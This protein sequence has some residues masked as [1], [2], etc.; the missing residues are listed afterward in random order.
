MVQLTMSARIDHEEEDRLEKLDSDAAAAGCMAD[1]VFVYPIEDDDTLTE[2]NRK[3][4]EEA[5]SQTGFKK[6]TSRLLGQHAENI[7]K[8]HDE[9]LAELNAR[10]DERA[11]TI[12]KM[13]TVNLTVV[14]QRTRDKTK[15]LVKVTASRKR[16][17]K[18]AQRLGIEMR[19]KEEFNDPDR[20]DVATYRDFD[21]AD[22]DDFQRKEGRLFST[23]ERQRLIFSILEGPRFEGCAQLDLDALVRRAPP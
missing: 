3:A 10:N 21:T 9:D 16:L 19:L 1:I 15:M 7:Q 14:K 6:F 20:P 12:T 11:D 23:L 2:E 17:E 8:N 13:R 5:N 18:E 22:R 4:I